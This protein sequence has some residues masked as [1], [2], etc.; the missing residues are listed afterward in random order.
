MAH[1]EAHPGENHGKET[2]L[3]EIDDQIHYF[4]ETKR[5]KMAQ[6]SISI[7]IGF[8]RFVCFDLKMCSLPTHQRVMCLNNGSVDEV[9]HAHLPWDKH[10]PQVWTCR[11]PLEVICDEKLSNKT[12][13]LP[14]PLSVMGLKWGFNKWICLKLI[15]DGGIY[16]V[17]LKRGSSV[18]FREFCHI[19]GSTF[20]ETYRP[21]IELCKIKGDKSRPSVFHDWS[22]RLKFNLPVEQYTIHG[23]AVC[24]PQVRYKTKITCTFVMHP[25]HIKTYCPWYGRCVCLRLGSMT[26]MHLTRGTTNCL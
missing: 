7:G 14:L 16:K 1:S 17:T 11:P 12:T 21:W 15:F 20:W 13:T 10:T 18:G 4:G 25:V 5:E 24:F 9:C 8:L 3:G 26:T 2:H 22:P 6:N 23:G 19:H